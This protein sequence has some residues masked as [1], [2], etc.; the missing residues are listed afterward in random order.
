[1]AIE[2]LRHFLGWCTVANYAVLCVWFGAFVLARSWIQRLHGRWFH[3]SD[4]TFDA[5]HYGGMAVYKILI[6]VLNLVPW[7][8]LSIIY[9]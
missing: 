9:G 3:L 5:L 7:L 1:M 6:L 2:T 8:V 4:T